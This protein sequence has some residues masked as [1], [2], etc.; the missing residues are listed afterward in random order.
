MVS[1]PGNTGQAWRRGERESSEVPKCQVVQ[2]R[3]LRWE[4]GFYSGGTREPY[5]I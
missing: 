4:L 3:A 1:C 2:G 5:G